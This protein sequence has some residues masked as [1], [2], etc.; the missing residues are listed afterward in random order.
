MRLWQQKASHSGYDTTF[1]ANRQPFLQFA[2]AT[3]FLA[4][5]PAFKG[6]LLDDSVHTPALGHGPIALAVPLKDLFYGVPFSDRKKAA[7]F[8]PTK[9]PRHKPSG[10]ITSLPALENEETPA[11]IVCASLLSVGIG[12]VLV[13]G[14]YDQ[15]GSSA[16]QESSENG[17]GDREE[18]FSSPNGISQF[19][20]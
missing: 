13:L 14:S 8:S 1:V 3:S 17:G 12:A 15:G 19:Y 18:G 16:V 6:Y 7:D 11:T 5:H 2:L 10:T 20:P 9:T 4:F